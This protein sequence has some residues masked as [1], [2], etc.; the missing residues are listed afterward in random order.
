MGTILP[1][2]G[3]LSKIPHGWFLCDGN[4]N[5]PDLRNR[6]LEGS[7]DSP[8]IFKAA[9]IPNITGTFS[10]DQYANWIHKSSGAFKFEYF[11]AAGDEG[12]GSNDVAL[13]SFDASRCSSI[14]GNSNTVQPKSYT[15]YY[16]IRMM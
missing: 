10:A 16:I 8:K 5:T 14:Y 13:F 4:N 6:F 12:T 11:F 1:Y 7:I 15:V 9:G 2:I 3:D